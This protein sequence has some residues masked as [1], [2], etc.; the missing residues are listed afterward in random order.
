MHPGRENLAYTPMDMNAKK[1]S[2]T[3]TDNPTAG[4]LNT[5]GA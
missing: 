3:H 2:Q 5:S 4:L 1:E